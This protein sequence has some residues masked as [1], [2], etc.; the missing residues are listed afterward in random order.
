MKERN[1]HKM[2]ECIIPIRTPTLA[3]KAERVLS[4]AGIR[5]N[6]VSVDPAVT[7]HGCG[8]GISVYCREAD[9]ARELLDRRRISYGDMIGGYS[10]I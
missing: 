2:T 3:K 1:D 9:R 7:K 10:D 5:V 4:A 8:Y 6:I